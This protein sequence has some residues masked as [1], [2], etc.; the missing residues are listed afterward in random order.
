MQ[1]AFWGPPGPVS[2]NRQGGRLAIHVDG[3]ILCSKV[4]GHF[5]QSAADRIMAN[6][7]EL[8]AQH[9]TLIVFS[10]WLLMASYDISCRTTMTRWGANLGRRLE[11]LCSCRAGQRRR[12]L[13]ECRA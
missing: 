7:D 12:R 11:A 2:K 8:V 10:D 9:G 4:T 1:E 3:P 13:E 6:G 5:D